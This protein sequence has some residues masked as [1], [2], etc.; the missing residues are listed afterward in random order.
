MWFT[1]LMNTPLLIHDENETSPKFSVEKVSQP[2]PAVHHESGPLSRITSKSTKP[3][4][5]R[6]HRA[7]STISWRVHKVRRVFASWSA[8]TSAFSHFLSLSRAFSHFYFY[9]PRRGGARVER[10]EEAISIKK[11]ERRRKK[12]NDGGGSVAEGGVSM[13]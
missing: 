1:L 5:P 8:E 6:F 3:Q 4:S 11:K 10:L 9:P 12:K 7:C 13:S 2:Q